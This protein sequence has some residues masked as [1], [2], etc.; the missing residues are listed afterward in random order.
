MTGAPLLE[1][2]LWYWGLASLLLLPRHTAQVGWRQNAAAAP[3]LVVPRGAAAILGPQN[4]PQ[5][6]GPD[7]E[8]VNDNHI[9]S[10]Y[11]ALT[12]PWKL[13]LSLQ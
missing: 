9:H 5:A 12:G 1:E 2:V 8:I 11:F 13:S 6:D 4:S 10:F 7:N 3:Q